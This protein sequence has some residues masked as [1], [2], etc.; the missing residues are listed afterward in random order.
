[1]TEPTPTGNL[2]QNKLKATQK[3]R[4]ATIKKSP[5]ERR[6]ETERMYDVLM[7]LDQ[8]FRREEATLKLVLGCLYDVG[9]V[10]LINQ[11]VNHQTAN[12]LVKWI[13]S[14]SKPIFGMI[15]L[16]WF[17][18]NCPQLL[19][20]WLHSKLMFEP[21]SKKSD[22]P[23]PAA[24]A[25]EVVASELGTSELTA[26]DVT[27][28]NVQAPH[29]PASNAPAPH[30]PA[31]NTAVSDLADPGITATPL[32]AIDRPN[33]D[34]ADTSTVNGAQPGAT[35]YPTT[36]ISP[37]PMAM[38]ATLIKA[39]AP[40]ALTLP[41]ANSQ[42]VAADLDGANRELVQLRSRVRV[43]T[44]LLLGVTLTLSSGIVWLAV[45][46]PVNPRP[47]SNSTDTAQLEGM[48]DRTSQ[49]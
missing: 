8:M 41:L 36:V 16:R 10:N 29:V 11:K 25:S 39:A 2:P 33:L 6:N 15:A 12:R 1:M 31:S 38:G 42:L 34:I 43:L 5:V 20:D 23:T 13:A 19:V 49:P 3:P 22:S 9:S 35:L 47:I 27:A 26:S 40:A 28:P 32:N 30:V 44:M 21:A 46:P 48:S 24:I 18:K 7:L 17:Y 4:K 37:S 14:L 45:N